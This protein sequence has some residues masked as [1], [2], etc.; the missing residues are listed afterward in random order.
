MHRGLTLGKYAPFHKGHQLVIETALAEVHELIVIIYDAEELTSVPLSVRAERIR[1]L[2][3]Q[4]RIIEAWDGPTEVGDSP[5]IKTAHEKYIL[6]T[7]GIARIDAFYS[8][9]FYGEHMSLA[10]KAMNRQVDPERKQVQISGSRIRENPFRYRE[11]ME[12]SVYREFITNIVFLG[13][14]CTGK[15]SICEKL[16]EE[17]RTEWMP[18]FGREYWEKHQMNRRLSPDQLTEIA[19]IHLEKENE[20]ILNADKYL[21]TD[22]NAI[23]TYMFSKYYH[24]YAQQRLAE[25]ALQASFRYDLVFLCDTDI[26]YDDTWDRSGDMQRKIFQKQIIA[27]LHVRK[28]PYYLLRGNPEERAEKVRQVMNRHQKY[29]NILKPWQF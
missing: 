27:D 21:F 9:E 29:E 3:P 11:F 19:E 22:T 5:E 2:Y 8:S 18:E 13:A 4:V 14:P 16:A 26:P 15:T 20:K 17:F 12:P 24:G 28:I 23:T 25:L 10:L 6:E 1:E 7:L